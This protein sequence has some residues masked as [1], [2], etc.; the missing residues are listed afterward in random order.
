MVFSKGGLENAVFNAVEIGASSF[1]LFLK[2]QRQWV[3]KPMEESTVKKF[4]GEFLQLQNPI[5]LGD[6]LSSC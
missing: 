3:A 1:A 6:F 4:K 5:L 2:S